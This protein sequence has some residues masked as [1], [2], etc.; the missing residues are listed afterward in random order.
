MEVGRALLRPPVPSSRAPLTKFPAMNPHSPFRAAA[1]ALCTAVFSIPASA[2]TVANE[3]PC[4]LEVF[5]APPLAYVVEQPAEPSWI[6]R[7]GTYTH[8]PYSGARVAQYLRT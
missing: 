2:D 3:T 4:A 5:E 6:F 8:D 1:I 7:R